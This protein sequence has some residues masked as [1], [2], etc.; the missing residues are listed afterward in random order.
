MSKRKADEMTKPE[1]NA[2]LSMSHSTSYS[3]SSPP[4]PFSE[5]APAPRRLRTPYSSLENDGVG[6]Q[7]RRSPANGSTSNSITTKQGSSQAQS[8]KGSRSRP[9]YLLVSCLI[10]IYLE[11][12]WLILMILRPNSRH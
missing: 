4:F 3:S 7:Q 9:D 2:C 6:G 1:Q 11:L 8:H 12:S 5:L 10:L